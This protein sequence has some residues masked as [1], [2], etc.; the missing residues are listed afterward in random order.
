MKIVIAYGHLPHTTGVYFERALDSMGHATIYAGLP[1][2]AGEQIASGE[3]RPGFAADVDL[4]ELAEPDLVV[5]VDSGLPYFPRGLDQV[6]APTAAYLIDVH[7]NLEL[8]QAFSRFFDH[9]F[10]AQRDY[11]ELIDHPS[12]HWLPLACDPELHKGR[13]VEKEWDV[14]F[15]GNVNQEAERARK[16]RLV[17]EAF[18]MNDYFTPIPKEEISDAYSRARIVFNCAV[19]NEVNMR[20]FEGMASGSLLVTE[21]VDNGQKLL[22]EDG[23]HLVEYS[24]D[25][26]MIDKIRHYLEHEDERSEIAHAGQMLVLREHTYS[27]RCEEILDVVARDGERRA[28]V[29]SLSEADALVEYS[30]LYA[31]LRLVDPQLRIAA[32]LPAG[33]SHQMRALRAAGSGFARKAG[34]VTGAGIKVANLRSKVRGRERH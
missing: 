21:K 32:E 33:S 13:E 17:S 10:V 12:V 30:Q 31:R 6:R 15:V 29:R 18:S 5:F 20:V 25:E 7:R 19:G 14:G 3:S 27:R 4:G 24:G 34:V 22:F 9:V 8:E 11:V 28:P 26:E 2:L 23:V 16:L 1:F